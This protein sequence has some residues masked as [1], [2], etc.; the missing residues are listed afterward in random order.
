MRPLDLRMP[1]RKWNRVSFSHRRRRQI[2]PE[3]RHKLLLHFLLP[4][5]SSLL[6]LPSLFLCGIFLLYPGCTAIVS[7][8]RLP[9]ANSHKVC[10]LDGRIGR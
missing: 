10:K 5:F 3:I 7:G 8:R 2:R 6:R 1:S 4:P 9:F